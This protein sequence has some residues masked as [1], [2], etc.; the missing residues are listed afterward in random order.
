MNKYWTINVTSR[1]LTR[2]T[3]PLPSGH[4]FWHIRKTALPPRGHVF[5]TSNSFCE[6]SRKNI[7]TNVMTKFHED[8]TINVTSRFHEDQTTNV[9]SRVFTKQNVDD[10]RRTTHDGQKVIPKAH[11]EYVVFQITSYCTYVCLQHSMF[12][13]R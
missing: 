6:L 11:H 2:R 13:S 12:T 1:V 9:A 4:V 10:E 8:L 5:Q 7:K 3:A